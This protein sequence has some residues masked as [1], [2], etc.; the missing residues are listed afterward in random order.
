[1][2]PRLASPSVCV[3]DDEAAEYRPILDALLQLGLGCVHVRGDSASAL[4]PEPFKGLRLVFTDLHLA[5]PSGKTGAAHTANIF[6][7]VVSANTAPVVV[8]I[9]S[10]YANDVAEVPGAPPEDDQPTEAE[11]FKKELLEAGPAFKTR[12]IFL[13]MPKPK[14]Q[15][16]P[17]T[18]VWIATLKREVEAAIQELNAFSTLW[19]WEALVYDAG[20]SVSALLTEIAYS[21]LKPADAKDELSIPHNQLKL[22]LKLLSQQQGGPDCA[23]ATA[24]RHLLTVLSQLGQDEIEMTSSD[25][26]LDSQGNW[27]AE[28]LHRD[29]KKKCRTAKLN[30]ILLTG[31]TSPS[32]A[33][34]SPGTVFDITDVAGFQEATGI[35]VERLQADCCLTSDN[36]AAEFKAQTKPVV[37]EVTPACDFH[38]GHRRSALLIGGIACPA[39]QQKK[40]NSKD[41]CKM[42]PLFEDRFTNPVADWVLVFCSRH[43]LTISHDA[44]P[45]WLKPRL[46]LRDALMADIRNWYASQAARVG[47]LSF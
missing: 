1:M 36:V 46:R 27:L 21:L 16:R 6:K 13:E 42:T 47:Y 39:S 23:A 43:R 8:I 22:L 41:A 28:A 40:A 5:A 15:D 11:Q 10:K 17:E 33:A 34:F 7:S 32:S 45:E 12:L 29:L 37:L 24:P 30:S 44:H 20:L 2:I 25:A 31:P 19:A 38:Q 14:P 35:S 26:G 3:I 18:D 9:W 4:P